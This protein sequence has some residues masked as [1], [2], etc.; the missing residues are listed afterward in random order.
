MG[1]GRRVV[2]PLVSLLQF[3]CASTTPL[4]DPRFAVVTDDDIRVFRDIMGDS[5][6]I[7][8]EHR[9]EPFNRFVHLN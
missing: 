8:D 7:T 1:I 4:R 6:V 9:L 2:S 3:R 5:G